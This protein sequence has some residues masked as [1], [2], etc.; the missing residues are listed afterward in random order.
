MISKAYSRGSRINEVLLNWLQP[1]PKF[2][3]LK[4]NQLLPKVFALHTALD[5]KVWWNS[6]AKAR[7][8][9]PLHLPLAKRRRKTSERINEG[10]GM[11]RAAMC[12]KRRGPFSLSASLSLLLLARN[13]G[14]GTPEYEGRLGILRTVR[15]SCFVLKRSKQ[16][17]TSQRCRQ[18]M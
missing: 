16:K 5:P 9:Y 4:E 14:F 8:G 6:R 17:Q 18:S 3:H 7:A 10:T 12:M 1:L 15:A 13:Q 2:A 11:D